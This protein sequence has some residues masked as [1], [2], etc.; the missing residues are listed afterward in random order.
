MCRQVPPGAESVL[1]GAGAAS[2]DLAPA[3]NVEAL[4]PLLSNPEFLEK[5]NGYLKVK[6]KKLDFFTRVCNIT[7][8]NTVHLFDRN[9]I[10]FS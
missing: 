5:V 2:V 9:I 6:I 3:L 10:F 4:Q 8:A 1:S 7:F